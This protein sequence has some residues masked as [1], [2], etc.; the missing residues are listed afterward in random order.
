MRNGLKSKYRYG[1][2]SFG[3]KI[4]IES[5][6][7]GFLKKIVGRLPEIIPG[8]YF[9]ELESAAEHNFFVEVG[10]KIYRFYKDGEEI[11]CGEKEDIFLKFF[12]SRLRLTVAEFAVG[13]VFLH[14]GVVGWKDRAIVIPGRSFSGKTTIIA[15]LLRRGAVYYSDEYAVLDENGN[16]HPFPKTLSVRGIAG[17]Y[18]Q[19]EFPAESF[20]AETA[21]EPIPVGMVLL[22]KYEQGAHWNPKRLSIGK[23]VLEI[24]PHSI[25]VRFNPKFTLQVLNN[26]ANRAIIAKSKRGEAEDVVNLLLKFFEAEVT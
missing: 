17:E 10:E 16:T 26:L 1:F 4:G 18:I 12:L 5:D 23:G 3:V 13:K 7:R 22:L 21:A 2:E 19:T 25:P 15:E 14:A 11:S 20:K 9:S 8:R 6:S 24:L